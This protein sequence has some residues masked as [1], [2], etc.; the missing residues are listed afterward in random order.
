V[1]SKGGSESRDQ[2]TW[3]K[4]ELIESVSICSNNPG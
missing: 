3:L 2:P 1:V 4:H